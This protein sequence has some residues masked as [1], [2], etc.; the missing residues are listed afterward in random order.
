[1]DSP[2]KLFKKHLSER[3]IQM[4]DIHKSV[5]DEVFDIH[6]HFTLEE[7]GRRLDEK[8]TI[9]QAEATLAHMVCAGLVRKVIFREDQ[10]FY[11][12]VYGHVHHDHLLCI[13]CGKV[14]E[15]THP[16]IEIN[17]EIVAREY[18]FEML[19][20]ALRIEGL[21]GE[22]R[23]I[24]DSTE[25]APVPFQP[26]QPE[27]PLSMINNGEHVTVGAIHGGRKMQQRLASM[28]IIQGDDIEILQN[29]FAGPITVRTRDSRIAIG[30]GMSH[31]IFVKP[32]S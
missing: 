31:K 19:R 4:T 16:D 20:H 17:Q 2:K 15:F 32:V 23:I 30:H 10:V 24:T 7:L 8:V 29:T 28:G 22:C 18:G 1:M 6:D 25:I 13:G 5:C 12:H 27:M 11:E 21:C 9:G 3:N 14:V 26:K